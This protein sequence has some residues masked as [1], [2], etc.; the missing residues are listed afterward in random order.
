MN[1]RFK[2][3][4]IAALALTTFSLAGCSVASSQDTSSQTST[5]SS[6]T[7]SGEQTNTANASSDLG[8]GLT[9]F[10]ADNTTSHAEAGDADY[11]A[12]SATKITLSNEDVTI[13]EPGTY[14]LSGTLTD[15][16]VRV[17]SEAE[18]KVR[19]VFDGVTISSST[20]SPVVVT[21]AD[22]VVIVLADGSTNKITDNADHSQAK[23][24]SD[25]PDAAIF[26]MADLTITGTGS[27]QVISTTGDGIG[28]K[29]GLVVQSGTLTVKAADDAVRGK[30]YVVIDGGVLELTAA[31]DGIK[32]TNE[33]DDTVGYVYLNGGQISISAGDDGI[34]AEGDLVI[35]GGTT[36]ITTSVEAIE[37]ANVV[38]AGG[39]TTATSSDDG[40]NA[41]SGNTT[42]GNGMGEND[43]SQM[44]LMGGEITVNASG[45]GLD[46]NGTIT[47]TGGVVTVNGPTAGA[48][49][50]IDASSMDISGGT[51]AVGGTS[52]MA[53]TPST[54]SE[55]GWVSMSGSF[56]A[57]DTITVSDGSTTLM[58]YTLGVASQVV[59]LSTESMTPGTEYTVTVNGSDSTRVV[60]NSGELSS[61]GSGGMPPGG[62]GGGMP[63]GGSGGGMAPGAGKGRPA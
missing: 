37:G 62:G 4:I 33:D 3:S 1:S 16:S 58:T 41:T 25:A 28:T 26:S 53:M 57:G 40:L 29:D 48:N 11:D 7:G 13:T 42:S 44:I 10:L 38:I 18:G 20:D 52:Q 27:L 46:S 59:V 39:M 22:E 51:L 14:V 45:D 35:A 43:G 47:M 36:K 61:M 5:V 6:S 30:D 17:A 55:Q 50:S 63:P 49:G 56:S 12:T 34:H 8:S 21:A 24:N 19:L 23:T 9:A 54:N 2:T 60:A 31:Q 32:S 15:H